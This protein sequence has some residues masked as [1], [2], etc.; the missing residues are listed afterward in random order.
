MQHRVLHICKKLFYQYT[1]VIMIV[2]E[3]QF[4]PMDFL[5]KNIPLA[6]PRAGNFVDGTV[7]GQDGQILFVDLSPAGTGIIYGREYNRAKDIIKS[8]KAGDSITVKI[9]ELENEEGYLSL[10]L[11]EAKEEVIWREAEEM[12]KSK[13]PIT[14]TVTSANKGG[15]VLEWNGIQGFLPTSQLKAN[16]YPKVEDSD[17]NKIEEELKKLVGE[18][19]KVTIISS[20]QKEKKLIFSEKNSDMEEIKEVTS[21]YK[22][23]DII[24][25]EVTGIVDFGIFV[26]ITNNLEGLAHIS[27]LD[28]VLIENPASHFKAGEKVKA[29]IINITDGKISLSLKALKQDPW[30]EIKDK[31]HTGDKVKGVIIKF[32]KYGALASIEEGVAGLVHISGFKSEED[33]KQKL[34]LGKSYSF[35]IVSF[36]PKEH[37]LTLTYLEN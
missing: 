10:S 27:E 15:L 17:K 37:R 23:G 7:I 14:L 35:Q 20:D 34:E 36:D 33:M 19:I 4:A 24:D 25:G 31:Y 12:Q 2:E 13:V 21:K 30:L 32:N 6:V 28:W 1:G 26:K 29:Q 11:K 18:K 9:I 5:M 16:H 8:L 3:K 22:V